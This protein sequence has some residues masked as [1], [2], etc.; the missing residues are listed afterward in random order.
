MGGGGGGVG[1]MGGGGGVRGS[2]GRAGGT[3]DNKQGVTTMTKIDLENLILLAGANA[4]ADAC[5]QVG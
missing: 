3:S 2:G 4:I 5:A 1:G